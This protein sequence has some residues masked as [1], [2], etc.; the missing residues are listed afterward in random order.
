MHLPLYA[1]PGLK[2]V[3]QI[4]FMELKFEHGIWTWTVEILNELSNTVFVSFLNIKYQQINH[5]PTGFHA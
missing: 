2:K 4:Y 5:V 1:L 3:M